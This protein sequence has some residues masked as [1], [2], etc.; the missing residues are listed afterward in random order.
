M[1]SSF[2]LFSPSVA[3][4]SAEITSC[5]SCCCLF[6][7]LLIFYNIVWIELCGYVLTCFTMVYKITSVFLDEIPN[8]TTRTLIKRVEFYQGSHNT[9]ILTSIH[10]LTKLLY[11]NKNTNICST[12]ILRVDNSEAIRLVIILNY[13]IYI[14]LT[15]NLI[16]VL[17]FYRLF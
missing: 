3:W 16:I 4:S 13:I 14:S 10:I 8:Q 1:C 15:H 5:C 7:Y 17:S 12:Y 6:I 9:I 2:S 11:I